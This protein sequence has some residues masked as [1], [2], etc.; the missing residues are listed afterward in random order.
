MYSIDLT[1]SR[2]SAK[3]MEYIPPD[4]P[5]IFK[6]KGQI[7]ILILNIQQHKKLGIT[8]SEKSLFSQTFLNFKVF[9]INVVGNQW[10][11]HQVG[12]SSLLLV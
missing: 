7:N 9:L 1:P 11:V 10:N 4:S 2:C 8:N 3:F 6:V 12:N 5:L